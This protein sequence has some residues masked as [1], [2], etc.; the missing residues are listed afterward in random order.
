MQQDSEHGE[1]ALRQIEQAIACAR[2]RARCPYRGPSRTRGE[3]RARRAQSKP[4]GRR[5]QFDIFGSRL[6]I[7]RPEEQTQTVGAACAL[8]DRPWTTAAADTAE[9]LIVDQAD[10]PAIA[11]AARKDAAT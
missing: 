1:V 8:A 6:K 7:S 4:R 11:T 2:W 5:Y 9:R 3:S 10:T